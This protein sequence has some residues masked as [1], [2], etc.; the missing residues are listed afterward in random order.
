MKY[1]Y[2]LHFTDSL[3]KSSNCICMGCPKEDHPIK[4]ENASIYYRSPC[5]SILHQTLNGKKITVT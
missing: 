1:Q 3:K 5:F 4:E 2:Y